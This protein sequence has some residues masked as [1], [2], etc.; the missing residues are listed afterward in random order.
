MNRLI[1]RESVTFDD[2][3]T[4]PVGFPPGLSHIQTDYLILIFVILP[5]LCTRFGACGP[6]NEELGH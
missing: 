4:L 3:S 5:N 6:R 1:C 2:T